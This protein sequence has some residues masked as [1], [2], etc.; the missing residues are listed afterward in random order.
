ME[1]DKRVNLITRGTQEIF[2]YDDLKALLK[3]KKRIMAYCGVAPTGAKHLGNLSSLVKLFDFEKAGI[4]NI[5]LMADIHAALDDLK[6]PWELIH[7]TAKVNQKI[8]ELSIP[9]EQKPKFVLGSSFQLKGDY[10]ND[11]LKLS[12]IITVARARRAASEVCRMKIPKVSELIYP[13]MQSLDEEYLKV[14]IQ[15]GGHDQ[16]HILAL[17]R[18]YLPK[19]G[20][21]KRVEV[22]MPLLTS[23][24]GP[25]VKM[26]A[27][28]PGTRIKPYESAQEIKNKIKNAYCPVGDVKDNPIMQLYQYFVFPIKGKIKITRSRKYGGDIEYKK[29][30]DLEKDFTNKKLHPADAKNCLAENLIKILS[31]VRRYFEKRKDELKEL[32][33]KY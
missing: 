27:S 2:T 19:I 24:K 33:A 11:V 30:E 6:A 23:L 1:L 21:K 31:K 8:I 25:G 18:E 14:D 15:L 7:K 13:I 16:R 12:T 20:Y 29:F 32:G 26:S 28:I 3:T 5:I 17:A 4:K 10:F 22:M 9:W